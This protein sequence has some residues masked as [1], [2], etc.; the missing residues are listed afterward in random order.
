MYFYQGFHSHD[1]LRVNDTSYTTQADYS[2]HVCRS[3][4]SLSLL[5]VCKPAYCN[6]RDTD[7]GYVEMDYGD[8]NAACTNLD[9]TIETTTPSSRVMPRCGVWAAGRL[10]VAGRL[11]AGCRLAAGRWAI[12]KMTNIC[13]A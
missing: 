10:A 12:G 8:M 2:I 9:S 4:C 7:N 6:R 13:Y 3:D 1:V 5:R 11:L